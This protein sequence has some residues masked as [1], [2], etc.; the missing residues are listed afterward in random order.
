[1]RRLRRRFRLRLFRPAAATTPPVAPHR[2]AAPPPTPPA[3]A[4]T[5]SSLARHKQQLSA[6]LSENSRLRQQLATQRESSAAKIASLRD[7]Q[8]ALQSSLAALRRRSQHPT[9]TAT[10]AASP[11]TDALRR[12]I[13][14]QRARIDR[15]S[16]CSGAAND[17]LGTV[18]TGLS[19]LTQR[20]DALIT[21][22]CACCGRGCQRCDSTCVSSSPTS[23]HNTH[24]HNNHTHSPDRARSRAKR[25]DYHRC[26]DAERSGG[27]I[28]ISH[29]P[30]VRAS[31]I[32]LSQGVDAFQQL[33]GRDDELEQ[34]PVKEK[35]VSGTPPPRT[36]KRHRSPAARPDASLRFLQ[37]PNQQLVTPV[38][39]RQ[40]HHHQQS[41]APPSPSTS[42][43]LPARRRLQF[44][45]SDQFVPS[46]DEIMP[47]DHHHHQHHPLFPP[48]ASSALNPQ[49]QK[50]PNRFSPRATRTRSLPFNTVHR[51]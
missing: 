41:E 40:V 2:A 28:L 21:L 15:L 12:V 45:P 8:S 27:A 30:Q 34:R 44:Q 23:S 7:T 42:P 49:Q 38:R 32:A 11:D 22:S 5:A 47:C 19:D 50:R 26:D 18:K 33:F 4:A 36:H 1:M 3:A 48:S 51:I 20:V 17:A 29:L 14:H 9:A 35:G 31:L 24:T 25:M 46:T 16:T 39:E 13:A 10:A 43:P 37:T 6:A